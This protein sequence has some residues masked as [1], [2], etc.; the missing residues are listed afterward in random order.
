ME[1][2]F[3]YQGKGCSLEVLLISYAS[4]WL[5]FGSGLSVNIAEE[6]SSVYISQLNGEIPVDMNPDVIF[7]VVAE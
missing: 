4:Y 6:K 1:S 7:Y 3:L 5:V 2:I